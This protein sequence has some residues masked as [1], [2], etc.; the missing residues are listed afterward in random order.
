MISA[1]GVTA[2]CLHAGTGMATQNPDTGEYT[3]ATGLQTP[4]EEEALRL[5]SISKAL[6]DKASDAYKHFKFVQYDGIA[7]EELYPM[8]ME[9]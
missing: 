3:D 4:E 7:E 6:T 8:A 1:V 5:D 9:T 2:L